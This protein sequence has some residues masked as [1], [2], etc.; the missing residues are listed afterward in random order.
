MSSKIHHQTAKRARKHGIELTFVI[1]GFTASKNGV[2]LASNASAGV[3]LEQAIAKLAPFP[4]LASS[5]KA[6]CK[7]RQNTEAY[8]KRSKARKP[9]D[10]DDEDDEPEEQDEGK[11]IIKSKYKTKYRPWKMTCGDDLA[12]QLSKHLKVKDEDDGKMRVDAAKLKRFALANDCW[13]PKYAH[14][15]V[16]MRRLN[17]ANRL[18]AKI[19]K[20]GYKIVWSA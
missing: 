5:V 17:V 16:G 12:Q 4:S 15:N 8:A 2:Q 9:R 10:E 19:R 6:V 13:D 20:D 3:A 14:L 1:D 7:V 18:R 11:S